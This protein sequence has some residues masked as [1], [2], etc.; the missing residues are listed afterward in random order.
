M[1]WW[2]FKKRS[3]EQ[4]SHEAIKNSFTNIRHDM[5]Q[6]SNWI[7][8]FK[9]KTKEH[10]KKHETHEKNYNELLMKVTQ[11]E[12]IVNLSQKNISE[13]KPYD[14]ELP[15]SSPLEDMSIAERKA[16][17]ILS[18]LQNENGDKWVPLKKLAEEVYSQKEYKDSRSAISQL[19]SKLEFDGFIIKKRVGKY[20]YIQLNKEK[21]HLFTSE[22]INSEIAK[23]KKKQD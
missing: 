2:L 16:C 10:E 21:K 17:E 7:G 4:I 9:E 13:F 8:H 20:A 14:L 15:L 22:K 5:S 23:T 1:V 19:T 6:I 12:Q 18:A 3:D 11:L